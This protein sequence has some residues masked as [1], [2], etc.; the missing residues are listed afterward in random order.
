ME[1]ITDLPEE[2][3]KYIQDYVDVPLRKKNVT[4]IKLTDEDENKAALKI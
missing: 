3:L 2:E 4:L 1:D